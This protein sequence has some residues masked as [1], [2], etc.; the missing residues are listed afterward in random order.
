MADI[1][2]KSLEV[3]YRATSAQNIPSLLDYN[4]LFKVKIND[5]W[6]IAAHGQAGETLEDVP[7]FH[8]AVLYKGESAGLLSPDNEIISAGNNVDETTYLAAVDTYLAQFD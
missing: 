2:H 4:G 8:I 7:A 1:L 3:L 6:T 5:D